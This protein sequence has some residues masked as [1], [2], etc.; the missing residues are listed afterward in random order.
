MT[1]VH[2]IVDND[3]FII[4]VEDVLNSVRV[5]TGVNKTWRNVTEQYT[6]LRK[7]FVNFT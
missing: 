3:G 7:F 4:R 2:I 1:L 5:L 6:I